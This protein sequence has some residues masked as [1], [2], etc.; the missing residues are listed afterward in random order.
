M[1]A[2]QSSGASDVISFFTNRAGF[3]SFIIIYSILILVNKNP[4]ESGEDVAGYL[5]SVGGLC[6]N[7]NRL[8]KPVGFGE[9]GKLG[10]Y[11]RFGRAP[12]GSKD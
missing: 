7:G 2:E 10:G 6:I 3:H 1:S 4:P 5:V 9:F 12:Y 8:R 11:R